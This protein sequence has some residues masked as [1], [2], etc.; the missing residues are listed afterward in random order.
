VPVYEWVEHTSELELEIE[1]ATEAAVFVDALE[2]FAELVA[3]E[4]S[5]DSERR[6]LELHGDRESLLVAWLDE[7][8]F[9]AETEG[10]VPERVTE[11]DVDDGVL[12]AGVSGHIGEPRH[13][14]K[15]VT[16]HR[17]LFAPVGNGWL[18]RVV[19]DV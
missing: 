3:D 11:L 15:A 16:L 13:L 12:R 4:Q 7:L 5:A 8:A 2:A 18:A 10:F 17:L 1:A 19:L 6:E 14:V 9:L